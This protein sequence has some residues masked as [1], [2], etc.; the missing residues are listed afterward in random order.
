MSVADFREGDTAAAVGAGGLIVAALGVKFGKG[1]LVV[2]LFLRK[3]W[4]L[5]LIIPAA[6]WKF[7]TG[8]R[9]NADA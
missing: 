1:I 7:I 8:R 6:I 3:F 9:G 4:F 2:V 5:A